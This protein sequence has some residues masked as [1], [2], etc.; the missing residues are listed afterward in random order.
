MKSMKLLMLVAMLAGA[1]AFACGGSSATDAGGGDTGIPDGSVKCVKA[2]GDCLLGGDPCC[3]GLTCTDGKCVACIASGGECGLDTDC[4]QGTDAKKG[5]WC[6]TNSVCASC[7]KETGTCTTDLDCCPAADA[8]AKSLMCASDGTCKPICKTDADCT[9]PAICM[10]NGECAPPSCSSDADCGT[11]KCCSGACKADCG[12]GPPTGCKITSPGGV[13]ASGKTIQLYA[14]A[15]KGTPTAGATI[16]PGTAITWT[17]SDAAKVAVNASTGVITGG[18][19]AGEATI[20]ATGPSSMACGTVKYTNVIAPVG[21]VAVYVYNETTGA[22]IAGAYV[23]VGAAAAVQTDAAGMATAS[24]PGSV[25]VFA[26]GYT[27]VSVIGE[28]ATAYQIFLKPET[29]Q[30]KAGGYHGKFDFSQVKDD[31]LRLGITTTSIGGSLLNLDLNALIGEMIQTKIDL[32]Q[33]VPYHD[34]IALPGALWAGANYFGV[35]DLVPL[36][37]RVIGTNGMR[38]AWAIGGG[39]SSKKVKDLIPVITSIIGECSDMSTCPI[40]KVL[41]LALPLLNSLN[42]AVTSAFEVVPIN[43]IATPCIV[44]GTV[45]PCSESGNKPYVESPKM[46]DYANFPSLALKLTAKA[47]LRSLITLAEL[48]KLGG[49]CL[50]GAAGLAGTSIPELG[51]VPLG[52]TA[53][54][55]D[56]TSSGTTTNCKIH[57]DPKNNPDSLTEGQVMARFAPLHDGIEGNPYAFA[58]LAL[59]FNSIT[60]GAIALSGRMVQGLSKID[61]TY[62]FSSKPFIGFAEGASYEAATRTIKGATA[63]VA[64]TAFYQYH[65]SNNNGGW[66]VLTSKLDPVVLPAVPGGLA[67][68]ATAADMSVYP[69]STI[70]GVTLAK[71]VGETGDYHLNQLNVVVDAFSHLSCVKKSTEVPAPSCELK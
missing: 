32:T 29:D 13:V 4:C 35:P 69:V 59:D 68:R 55:V 57:W 20:T 60:S 21:G 16:V 48:P 43:K 31:A 70:A 46:A 52:I 61:K 64:N 56:P 30:N 44:D 22:P 38:T 11:Q 14:I 53:G 67:D 65:V 50:S 1:L 58:F 9:A 24:A 27:W 6:N 54:V 62:D 17:T 18:A 5:A 47:S 28:S 2:D 37:Y 12:Y 63:A 23:I 10:P 41:V 26:P 25:H 3:E 40:G 33:P 15:Y 39:L 19:T 36:N 7:A 8:T 66:L 51:L 34:W 45:Y 49:K 71:L 42:H